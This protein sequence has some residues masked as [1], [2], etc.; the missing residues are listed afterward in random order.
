MDTKE[1]KFRENL[2][3]SVLP[4]LKNEET[5]FV[6][7]DVCAILDIK[8]VTHALE[9]LDDD[10]K[11]IIKLDYKGQLREVNVLNESGLYALVL[12][13]NKQEAKL[14]RK[15]ITSEVLPALRK[16][17][18]Y[19]SEKAKEKQFRLQTL[20]LEIEDI[21][22]NIE[23]LKKVTRNLTVK[24]EEKYKLLRKLISMDDNQL[25]IEFE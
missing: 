10:E 25:E 6:A 8:S 1:F 13:S 14:F 5:W 24:K 9:R 2:S 20:S 15:W 18:K 11:Q 23:K 4:S 19:T 22:T 17:G 7:S 3:I 12:T 16:S 21:E